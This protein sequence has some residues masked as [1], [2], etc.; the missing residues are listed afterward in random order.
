MT[1]NDSSCFIHLLPSELLVAIFRFLP[2]VD[3]LQSIPVVCR[4]WYDLS[5]SPVLRKRLSLKKNTPP[6]YLLSSIR[7][8][9]LLDV[10]HSPALDQAAPM[11]P[12]ALKMCPTL[13]CLDVGFCSL[14]E[15]TADQLSLSMPSTLRHLN[16]EGV[17][18]V[19]LSFIK[20]LVVRCP[21]L[22]ALNLS[23]CVGVCD[24]CVQLIA[25]KLP[26]LKR[27]NLDGV[28]W[29]SDTALE[30]L[31]HAVAMKTGCLSALW[32]DGFELSTPGVRLFTQRLARLQ[33]SF[34]RQLP[35]E[36]NFT[37]LPF[38]GLQILWISFCDHLTDEA[39][40]P[41]GQLSSLVALTLRKAQQITS[42]SW[43]RLF[44][45]NIDSIQQPALPALRYLE[46]LDLSEAPSVNDSVVTDICQCCGPQLRSLTLNWCWDLTDVGLN[47]IVSTCSTL[48]HL[49]LVGNHLIRGDSLMDVCS[50]LPHLNIL[51]LTQCN[52]VQDSVLEHVSKMPDLYVF[53]YF[54]ERVGGQQNEICHYDLWRSLEK[55]PICTD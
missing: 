54:G 1:A 14:T 27:L 35:D 2:L 47:E 19:G 6:E 24:S 4:L 44:L 10:L 23:H 3:L 22:E 18:S 20:N 49:S 5:H 15:E 50:K 33:N 40:E 16:V 53:D 8:R 25:T 48:R 43:S 51:N 26:R 30:H 46:H 12:K 11:L 17:K 29:L 28:L 21:S 13:R 37:S 34:E 41:L 36:R 45:S 7:T 52:H 31:V 38:A 55:V 39:I 32:L 9:P 42:Q